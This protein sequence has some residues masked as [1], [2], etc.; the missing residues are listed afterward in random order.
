MS[1][2]D[3]ASLPL[4][5]EQL[6]TL[7]ALEYHTM[8]PVQAESLPLMLAG[9]DV[10][11]QA[12]TGS[13][14]TA[15]FALTVLHNLN[16]AQYA[17]QALVLCPTRELAE[18]VAEEIRRLARSQANVK[19]LTL[20][21]GV[22]TRDQSLSLQHGAHV[23]VGTPGRVLD[24]VSQQRLDLTQ[25]HTLVLD[26]AD[27]MLD[28]GFQAELDAIIEA[29]PVKRQTLL[30]SATFPPQIAS[31]AQHLMQAPAHIEVAAIETQA[32]I[33]KL[34][35]QLSA[36]QHGAEAVAHVLLA[37]QPNQAIVFCNTK[38]EADSVFTYLHNAGFSVQALHGDMEQKDREETLLL[39]NNQS[40][41][42]LVATDVAARGLDIKALDLVVNLGLAH[43]VETH[44]HRIGRTGRAG[45]AGRAISLLT[46]QCEY[47]FHLLQDTAP[48]PLSLQAFPD[49]APTGKPAPASMATIQ[50]QGGKK[51]KLRPG[52]IVG[53]LTKDG[54]LAFEQ[55]GKIKVQAKVAYVA[56]ARAKAK[57]ALAL[58]TEDKLKGRRFRARLV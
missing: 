34:F 5:P 57:H 7:A 47:K 37:Q 17:V 23:I 56:V 46:T 27:R 44:T 41:R 12:Q 48:A 39:F 21:G 55:V 16:V 8:T 18:Q 25:L 50:I 45:E 33:T 28:M 53:A 58:L 4:A 6:Q 32:P 10:I 35:Y 15:A 31:L 11:A 2:T 22:P 19:V 51:D 43:D 54:G 38:R 1:A 13:G 29:A 24:H 36:S 9:R 40:V 20:C 42:I 49:A 30:F 52:D 3:F 26:E 14:K